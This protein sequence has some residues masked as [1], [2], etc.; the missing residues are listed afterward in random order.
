MGKY[1]DPK[2]LY[3][4]LAIHNYNKKS[5]NQVNLLTKNPPAPAPAT[6]SD[7]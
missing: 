7:P 3:N 1:F 4:T 2:L 5:I 6:S